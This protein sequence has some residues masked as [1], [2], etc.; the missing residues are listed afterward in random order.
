METYGNYEDSI[1]PNP[2]LIILVVL[3][4]S[5]AGYID[6]TSFFIFYPEPILSN[7]GTYNE[8]KVIKGSS[9]FKQSV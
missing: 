8:L 3:P 9:I 6:A 1:Y 4:E 2:I 5:Q 7:W